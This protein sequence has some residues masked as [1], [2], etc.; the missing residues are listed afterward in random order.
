MS[1]RFAST[2]LNALFAIALTTVTD[3]AAQVPTFAEVV[4]HEFGERITQHHE[5]VSYLERLAERSDRVRL[6]EQGKTWEGRRILAAI[7]TSPENH[8]RL[9]RIQEA[10]RR[11]GD[12]RATTPE[13]AAAIIEQQPVIAWFGGSIHGFELSG[14]EGL[15]KLLEHLSTRD[16]RATREVLRDAVVLIDPMLN[17]DGRD[18]F[19]HLNHE[20]IGRLPNPERD[21][22]AND[23]TRWQA[24]KFR[25]GHYYFDTNRD[26]FAHTQRET[27][28]RV[29]TLQAWR[30]QVVVDAHEMSSDV[31]FYFDPATDPY[32]PYFPDF[33][34]RGFVRFGQAYAAAFDSAGFEYMTRERYNYFYP[35][36]TTS[37]G[38]YQGAI[39]ML[40]EQGS[41]RGLTLTR[42]DRSVRTLA[43]A[44]EQQYLAAWTAVRTAAGARATLLREY[45]EAHRAAVADGRAGI[46]RYLIGP[47]GDP[48]L[49]AELVNLLER[50]G[51][52]VDLLTSAAR[53]SD[54]RDREGRNVGRRE[55]PTGTYVVDAAQP[56]NRL[57]RTL[58]EPE[59]PLP[60]DFLRRARAR[61]DRDE[62]PRFYD[63]TAWSLPLLFNVGGY[64]TSDGRAL[65][66]ERVAGEARA[67]RAAPAERA[68][69]AYLI[70]GRQAASLAALYALKARGYR[71]AVIKRPTKVEGRHVAGGTVIVRV[72]Q[73]DE[74][75]HEAVREVAE[76]FGVEVRAVGTGLSEPGFPALGSG[77]HVIPVRRPEIAILAEDP[78]DAYSFGWAWYTLDRQYEIPVTVLRVGSIADTPLDRFNV[79]IVPSAS[80]EALASE[81]GEQGADRIER[82]VRDGG[83]L[84]TIGAAADFARERELIALRSWYETGE[85]KD[86]QHFGVPGAILRV[87]LDD[88]HW[89]SAGYDDGELPALVNSDRVYLPPA[90]PPSSRRRAAARYGANGA[91]RISGHA[92]DETLERLPD[93]VF[94]Y[95]ERVDRGRVIAFAEDVNFRAYWRGANR[96]FLNAVVLG[97]SAP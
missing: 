25:T 29:P 68:R 12:P 53:L 63:I 94:A 27:Q 16:D 2:A 85:G 10:A 71:A 90:G 8:A 43:D 23:F 14:S 31:E 42:A 50:N 47:E 87:V 15:L 48:V 92:W 70:D 22:W 76:H 57:I 89:L 33:A 41:T 80:G 9:D 72:G 69:Y 36:Y 30:P 39:G 97:P 88:G 28:A 51:I 19:A 37:Y 60:E 65:P 11:L 58:L 1:K 40:Y 32:G 26:W 79:L 4:G 93:A 24:L 62:N 18:A 81:L 91:L 38:S 96:L 21:D 82:W 56:R 17:P 45:Y 13:Q 44:L 5:M 73:N 64:S 7:V 86:A 3:A 95:E 75:V 6:I 46:R 49:I 78:I 54:V 84:I 74:T 35:G 66:L 52:E 61:V 59:Q 55:F 34:A 83:T 20:N 67:A 77:D